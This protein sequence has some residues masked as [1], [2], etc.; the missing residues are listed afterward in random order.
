MRLA[1]VD[2]DPKGFA[3][4]ALFSLAQDLLARDLR[5]VGLVDGPVAPDGDCHRYERPVL[6]LPDKAPRLI[7]QPLGP[8]SR[9]CR[10]DPGAV[11]DC[12]AETT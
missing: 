5:C 10:I 12:V 8:Y 3:T 7:A 9:G 6:L 4:S 2:L 1:Y 11:A